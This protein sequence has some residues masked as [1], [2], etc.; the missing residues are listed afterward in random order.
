MNTYTRFR[1][2][3]MATVLAGGAVLGGFAATGAAHASEDTGVVDG[4]G[5]TRNDWGD[6]GT[7]QKGDESNA[8]ALWQTVLM[9]DGAYWKDSGGTLHQ[10]TEDD[11]SGE[12]DSRT[13]SATKYWQKSRGLSQTGKANPKCFS[14]ADNNLGP[15]NK[16][17]SVVY[18]GDVDDVTFKRKTV[19]GYDEQVYYV[20]FDGSYVPATY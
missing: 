20:K 18:E 14:H 3:A 13:V 10:F 4:S 12:Y 7:L 19:A 9:A 2:A 8:V 17:G 1:R 11:I 5:K 16:K 6:E 15:V